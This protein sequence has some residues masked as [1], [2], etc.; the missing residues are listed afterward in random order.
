[1]K[2]MMVFGNS[3]SGKSTL[4]KQIQRE[5]NFGYLDLDTLAWTKA[6]V[7]TRKP[8]SESVKDIDSFLSQEAGWVIEGCYVDLLQHVSLHANEMIFL[9]PGTEVCIQHCRSRPWEPHK[10]SSKEEQDKN[11]DMLIDWVKQYDEREDEFS[12]KAHKKLF[13]SFD[14]IKLEKI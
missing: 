2:R 4:A 3:G 13:E 12:L 10:Y 1:M 11:L 6:S 9:N 14:G 8:L 7:P 5:F